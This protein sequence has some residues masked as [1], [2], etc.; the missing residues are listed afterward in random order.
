MI[1]LLKNYYYGA[2][3]SAVIF[4]VAF[5]AAGFGLLFTGGSDMFVYGF[6][7][8]SGVAFSFNAVSGFRKESSTKWN[9]YELTAPIKRKDIVKSRYVNHILWVCIGILLSTAFV[10]LTLLIHGNQYFD[11]GIRDILSLFSTSIVIALFMGAIFYPAIYFFGTDKSEIMIIISILGAVGA[12]VGIVWLANNLYDY[13]D[14][15]S[16][17]EFYVSMAVIM[18]T[19]IAAFISSCVLTILIYLRKEH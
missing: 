15:V 10:S 5:L 1:G 7:L 12:T 6:I 3:G 9:K 2:F 19:A 18:M 4:L 14:P 13:G 11:N 17:I 8:V 16:D